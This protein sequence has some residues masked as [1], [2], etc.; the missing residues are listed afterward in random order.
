MHSRVASAQPH[1]PGTPARP[2]AAFARKS[3]ATMSRPRPGAQR[4]VARATESEGGAPETGEVTDGPTVRDVG[5]GRDDS[6]AAN[7]SQGVL[8]PGAQRW[9]RGITGARGHQFVVA[10]PSMAKAKGVGE[11]VHQHVPAERRLGVG[12]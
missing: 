10:L 3:S 4:R 12:Q 5:R 11:F 6:R 2:P 1:P 9:I 8:I 7:L